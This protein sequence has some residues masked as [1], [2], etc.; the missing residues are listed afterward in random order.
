MHF[1]THFASILAKKTLIIP[2]L[3][4]LLISVAGVHVVKAERAA[5]GLD[6]A[7]GPDV[8]TEKN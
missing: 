1:Q 3:W 7:D 4:R 6:F 8:N 2:A 5:P